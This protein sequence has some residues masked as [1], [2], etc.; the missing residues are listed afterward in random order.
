MMIVAKKNSK[1]IGANRFMK[2]CPGVVKYLKYMPKYRPAYK[3]AKSPIKRVI[4]LRR[5]I[6]WYNIRKYV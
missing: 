4:C 1:V 2:F 6:L 5:Y 3:P